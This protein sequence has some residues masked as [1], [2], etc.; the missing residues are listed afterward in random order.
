MEAEIEI[1]PAMLEAGILAY[2]KADRRFDLDEEIV[3]SIYRAMAVANRK[4]D[5]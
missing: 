3:A 5:G 4:A 2:T 1:T